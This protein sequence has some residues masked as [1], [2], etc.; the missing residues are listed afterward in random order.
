MQEINIALFPV[1][2]VLLHG[3]E[4]SANSSYILSAGSALHQAG[5]AIFRLNLRDHGDTQAL[6]E[7]LF[8]SCRLDEV[9][10]AVVRIREQY[11]SPRFALVGQSLGGNFVLR[12]ATRGPAVGLGIDRVIA[13]CPVLRPHSTMQ[14][15]DSG[16][17]PYRTYFLNRWQQSLTAKALAHPALYDFGDLRRFRT[18][19]DTTAFFVEQYTEFDS[20]D[21]YLNGYSLT[22]SVLAELG[23][24]SRII[25]ADDDPIIPREDLSEIAMPPTLELSTTPYGGHCG[26]I[27]DLRALSW[28]DREIVADLA[29]LP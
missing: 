20:L 4:G 13:V 21:A 19:S 27:D 24:S 1:L 29:R 15:L 11:P 14:A 2:V 10:G 17:W 23:V 26:F 28:V 12:V 22:G 8:H 16:W 5:Y 3:W 7:G 6:N 25:L 9:L 18:L